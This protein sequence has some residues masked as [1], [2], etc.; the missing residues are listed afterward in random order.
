MDDIDSLLETRELALAEQ[1]ATQREIMEHVAL[2]REMYASI[3][4]HARRTAVGRHDKRQ[5][6]RTRP[7]IQEP[8][9]KGPL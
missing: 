7:V 8:N 3:P 2:Q 9:T 5:D 6:R 4:A 1:A